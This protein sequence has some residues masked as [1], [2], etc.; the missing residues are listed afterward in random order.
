VCIS[1]SKGI[2][3]I[4]M[5]NAPELY[6]ALSV[7]LCNDIWHKLNA[8]MCD[9]TSGD[10]VSIANE[11]RIYPNP[12]GAYFIIAMPENIFDVAIMD[13][14]GNGILNATDVIHS[15]SVPSDVLSSG[16]YFIRISLDSGTEIIKKI[17]LE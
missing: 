10:A 6:G 16:V 3:M 13:V 8:I 7:V 15:I 11:V 12:A 5:G 1:D 9:A 14:H 2:V 4:R 17:I